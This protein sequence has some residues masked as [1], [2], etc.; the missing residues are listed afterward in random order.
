MSQPDRKFELRKDQFL[1]NEQLVQWVQAFEPKF[2]KIIYGH[3][4]LHVSFLSIGILEFFSFTFFFTFLKEYSLI[5]FALA[6]LFLTL[7]S[8]Y[9]VYL[10]SQT[11]KPEQLKE[12]KNTF[13]NGAREIINY[14]HDMTDSHLTLADT[15][16]KLAYSLDGMEYTLF[17][18]PRILKR[19][20][21]YFEK[22]SCWAY[23]HDVYTIKEMVL[24]A[25]V[26]EHIKLVKCDAA[27]LEAHTALA[28]AYILLSALYMVP[29][30]EEERSRMI[31]SCSTEE[32]KEKFQ[33]IA[34]RAI[35]EF[36]ILKEY[37]PHD[38]W[39]H[40]QLAH[41]YCDLQMPLEAISEYEQILKLNSTDSETLYKLGILYFQ[42]GRNAHGLKVY[43]QLKRLNY[44]K[45]NT[46][47]AHY[48]AY[49]DSIFN[50]K[51]EI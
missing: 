2:R 41:S 25:M 22:L 33:A 30:E 50:F 18:P 34:K 31:S 32:L 21:S 39:I 51:K 12:L 8:Y 45:A 29:E 6:L 48:G 13:S 43:E 20:S 5:A 44:K 1:L 47:I 35:E 40:E 11:R 49:S 46:L 15:F 36:K 24:V 14:D 10:Y 27:N 3:I 26:E 9:I 17:N 23:W 28:N 19:L 42:L 38:P 16:C 7:F 4:A 37:S